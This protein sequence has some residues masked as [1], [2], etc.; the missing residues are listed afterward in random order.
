MFAHNKTDFVFQKNI[1]SHTLP[2]VYFWHMAWL[3]VE[4]IC[5]DVAQRDS[6][7]FANNWQSP[8]MLNE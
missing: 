6:C 1:A 5:F 8:S 3:S 7:K 2:V 4:V